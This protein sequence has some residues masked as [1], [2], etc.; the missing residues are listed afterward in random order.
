MQTGIARFP[1]LEQ[2]IKLYLELVR[3]IRHE[4]ARGDLCRASLPDLILL[5]TG[6]PPPAASARR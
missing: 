2:R 5:P 3:G 4:D 1:I 6:L